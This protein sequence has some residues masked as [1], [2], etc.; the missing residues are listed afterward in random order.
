MREVVARALAEDLGL[1]GDL[2][3]IAVIDES[4]TGTGR[5]VA[6][7]EGV[8]AGTAA[9][10]E[11][12]AQIDPGV[13]VDWQLADGSE[14]LADQVAGTVTGSMRSLLAG[15]RTAL[16]LLQH[17]SGIA[18]VTRRYVRAC[19]RQGAHPRHAQDPPRPPRRWRRRPCAPAAASTTASRCRTR[20]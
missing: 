4:A 14:L 19:T 20:C 10:T 17:C 11:T 8:L 5:F 16:N 9:A 15:E 18:T 3:S 7:G 12:F 2:T 6:R 13:R 1:L